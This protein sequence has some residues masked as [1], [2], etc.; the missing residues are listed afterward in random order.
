MLRNFVTVTY[1]IILK[2]LVTVAY[3]RILRKL[4][5]ETYLSMLRNWSRSGD[6]PENA[7]EN[8]EGQRAV[9][10]TQVVGHARRFVL[11]LWVATW[12]QVS[13]ENQHR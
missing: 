10:G 2:K 8:G 6:I 4:V 9:V 7:E 1:P 13:P 12:L 5:E 11:H 3:V